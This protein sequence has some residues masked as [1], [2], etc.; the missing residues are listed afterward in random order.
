MCGIN[1]VC[2]RLIIRPSQPIFFGRE[3]QI[4]FS[5]LTGCPEVSIEGPA[6]PFQWKFCPFAVKEPSYL[7]KLLPPTRPL[8]SKRLR[9]SP[10]LPEPWISHHVIDGSVSALGLGRR[11]DC[12]DPSMQNL[13]PAAAYI[14]MA[15]EFPGVTQLWDCSFEAAYILDDSVPPGTLEV[16]KD[17][18]SWWVK[19]SSALLSFQGDMEWTRSSPEFDTVHSCGKLGYGKPEIGPDPITCV[20]VD[21]V[22]SRCIR[23]YEREA[24]YAELEGIAQFGPEYVGSISNLFRPAL[25]FFSFAGS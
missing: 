16:S 8:N 23:T 10:D 22:L 11:V 6:Y 4:N 9:I 7:R 18:N 5:V 21:A 14:E 3:F 25:A 24:L 20:D 19:S 2:F 13:I 1:S 17:G 12:A 15:L